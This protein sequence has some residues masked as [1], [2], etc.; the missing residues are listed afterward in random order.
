MSTVTDETK[1][2]QRQQVKSL[3]KLFIAIP[4]PNRINKFIYERKSDKQTF[5]EIPEEY[6]SKENI[7]KAQDDL[8]LKAK[9]MRRNKAAQGI[10]NVF[11][12]ERA[13]EAKLR[14]ARLAAGGLEGV[15]GLADLNAKTET[16]D[17]TTGY[18]MRSFKRRPTPPTFY[19]SPTMGA[20]G[21]RRATR[22]GRN[23]SKKRRRKTR[24]KRKTHRRKTRKRKTRKRK[25]RKR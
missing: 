20:V 19:R 9:R 17:K 2:V 6:G 21:L 13:K 16:K 8:I 1:T 3:R 25:T 12:S 5:S 15:E 24:R 22:G 14:A 7:K 23:K 4:D 10:K 18:S 11:W